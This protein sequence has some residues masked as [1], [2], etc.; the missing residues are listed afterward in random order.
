MSNSE[1]LNSQ[2]IIDD[3]FLGKSSLYLKRPFS[4]PALNLTNGLASAFPLHI[5]FVDIIRKTGN[6]FTFLS[7]PAEQTY[8]HINESGY[9]RISYN[10]N[11]VKDPN[12]PNITADVYHLIAFST[13]IDY[14]DEIK[15]ILHNFSGEQFAINKHDKIAQIMLKENQSFLFGVDTED[16]R[17]GGFGSTGKW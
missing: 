11:I 2:G 1:L 12:F 14:K 10:I 8:I 17:V 6:A 7:T 4:S 9:Y 3:S 13:D 15:I 5:Q 16:E